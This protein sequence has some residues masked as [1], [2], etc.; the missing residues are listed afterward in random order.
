MQSKIDK[1]KIKS[2]DYVTMREITHGSG[3]GFHKGKKD[4]LEREFKKQ[5]QRNLFLD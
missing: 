5:K 3:C 1:N 2:R 4:Q